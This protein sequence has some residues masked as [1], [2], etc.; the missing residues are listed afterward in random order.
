MQAEPISGLFSPLFL[1][2]GGLF[3]QGERGE[4]FR[5][6]RFSRAISTPFAFEVKKGFNL[7]K[8]LEGAFQIIG[9]AELKEVI[10]LFHPSIALMIEEVRWHPT[11]TLKRERDGHLLFT[12]KVA[13]P[14]EVLW[15]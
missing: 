2:R 6:N 1:V 14:K 3:P 8:F 11:Q 4:V 5:L 7:E 15:W 10:L 13:E 9:G 12:V